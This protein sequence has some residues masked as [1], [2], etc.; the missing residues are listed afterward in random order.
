MNIEYEDLTIG[1]NESE[2]AELVSFLS[3]KFDKFNDER[4]SQL[5]DIKII[6][7]SIYNTNLPKLNAW[8]NRIELPDMYEL[9]QTL[10]SHISENLYSHPDAMFD[11]TGCNQDSQGFANCQK[12]M[13]VD[14]FEKMD[15]ENELDKVISGIV[16]AGEATLFVG[17]ETKFKNIRRLKTT[18]E[19]FIS[20]DDKN[21]VVEEKL[22]YDNP[23]VKFISPENFVFDK[24]NFD[25][26][27]SCKK[28]YRTYLTLDE[29]ISDK[30]NNFLTEEKT[31]VLKGVVAK[32][33]T[34]NSEHVSEDNKLEVIEFWGDVELSNGKLLKNWL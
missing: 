11:V 19:Q 25:N 27:D 8:N 1:L 24:A 10:K 17:W 28:F 34:K 26:W 16:E 33:K 9:A 13:L 5:N 4:V 29:I 18:E 2:E 31:E 30:S 15:I 12:A 23:K 3:K 7:D 32:N 20:K 22:V 6:K 21:F 14:V